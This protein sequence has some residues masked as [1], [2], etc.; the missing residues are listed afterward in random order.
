MATNDPA[1]SSY[2]TITQ[3][4]TTFNCVDKYAAAGVSDI[5]CNGY[6]YQPSSTSEI[7]KKEK[8]K[9]G[10]FHDYSGKIQISIIMTPIKISPT[11]RVANNKSLEKQQKAKTRREAL[12]KEEGLKK[13][14]NKYIKA[15]IRY[16]IHGSNAYWRTISDAT[17]ELLTFSSDAQQRKALKE[18]SIFGLK[19]LVI[20]SM[21][22]TKVVIVGAFQLNIQKITWK[23]NS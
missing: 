10:R 7:K 23:N 8:S 13:S 21:S 16:K 2:I 20:A 9:K 1:E 5:S 17:S 12:S 11:S 6:L 22:V 15:V 19:V 4:L 14:T 3:K 18:I